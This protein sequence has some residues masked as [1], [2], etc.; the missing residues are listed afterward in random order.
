MCRWFSLA[1]GELL[2]LVFEEGEPQR[3]CSAFSHRRSDI[4]GSRFG[5]PC[6]NGGVERT[7]K[8]QLCSDD[9]LLSWHLSLVLV[10]VL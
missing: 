9:F 7:R 4:A 8:E 10:L 2:V 6:C 1:F 5:V 3:N